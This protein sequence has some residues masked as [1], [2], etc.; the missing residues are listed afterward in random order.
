MAYSKRQRLVIDHA[1]GARG[2]KIQL[3]GGAT[4]S[5]KTHVCLRAFALFVGI[6]CFTRRPDVVDFALLGW[7]QDVAWRNTGAGLVEIF[8]QLQCE[9][10]RQGPSGNRFI[11]V[12][13]PYGGH[14]RVWLFGVGADKRFEWLRGA[15]FAGYFADE[16]T[17][18]DEEYWA[19]LNSRLDKGDVRAWCTFN[20]QHPGHWFKR[21]VIDQPEVWEAEVLQ[22]S[23]EDNPTLDEATKERFRRQF[24]GTFAA[25][26]VEGRW[27]AVEGLI[28]PFWAKPE[29]E[30]R[31]SIVRAQVERQHGWEPEYAQRI[32]GLDYGLATTMAVVGARPASV[33]RLPGEALK[34]RTRFVID[35][36]YYYD[37]R[38]RG[39]ART[40]A[41]HVKALLGLIPRGALIVVDP[42]TPDP[43]KALL[44]QHWMIRN[45]F[46]EDVL[47]GLIRTSALLAN[48][49][50]LIDA[51]HVPGLAEEID[52]YRWAEG[53]D[54]DRPQKRADHACD[55]LRYL[56]CYLERLV[57]VDIRAKQV[58]S[59]IEGPNWTEERRDYD[60]I[61][62]SAEDVQRES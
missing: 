33:E 59:V 42:S 54:D 21:D 60:V 32:W 40:D 49:D 25:R 34:W 47:E 14:G 30:L 10:R 5:G 17:Q 61:M 50:V 15:S 7:T 46:A 11:S 31:T 20:P 29:G 51:D 16:C 28:W 27:A 39:V 52:G 53:S 13:T 41:Q 37:A 48:G 58:Y 9:G 44:A 24:R 45:G 23:F 1:R 12:Q 8:R 18:M 22:F 26:M 35:M 3:V 6:T 56:G 43:F 19:M 57:D 36:E 4:R 55:A 38:K 2:C 62:G